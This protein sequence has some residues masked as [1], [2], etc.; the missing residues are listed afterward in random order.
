MV[1]PLILMYSLVYTYWFPG[2]EQIL[3]CV[4]WVLAAMAAARSGDDDDDIVVCM[5]IYCVPGLRLF[6]SLS[7]GHYYHL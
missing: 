7:D 3:W 6:L 5:C 1:Y 4:L 2:R